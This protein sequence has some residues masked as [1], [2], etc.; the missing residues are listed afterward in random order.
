MKR[1]KKTRS[2]SRKD[3]GLNFAENFLCIPTLDFLSGKGKRL[4]C[5]QPTKG[6]FDLLVGSS[7]NFKFCHW[8]LDSIAVNDFIKIPLIEAYNS[9]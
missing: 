7:R 9:V 5:G 2:L 3:L 1:I 8:S 6:P 4:M